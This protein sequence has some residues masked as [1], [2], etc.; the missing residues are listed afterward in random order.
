MAYWWVNHNCNHV[1]ER[2]NG[3]IWS[4]K[5]RTDGGYSQFYE[6]MKLIMPGDIIFSYAQAEVGALGLAL[7]KAI[8]QKN[9]FKTD[10]QE[11]NGWYVRVYFVSLSKPFKPRDRWSEIGHLFPEKYSPL[12]KK[13]GKGVQVAYLSAISDSLG[14]LL[15]EI[16]GVKDLPKI[17]QG[18]LNQDE[19]TIHSITGDKLF[20][21][22]IEKNLNTVECVGEKTTH[23]SFFSKLA[24]LFFWKKR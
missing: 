15:I 6:N 18:Y 4:P 17:L 10:Y 9:P 3:F 11:R 7:A 5:V 8:D 16:I 22:S 24:D 14:N 13:N 23:V 12:S 1:L 21:N 2:E 19:K 20:E